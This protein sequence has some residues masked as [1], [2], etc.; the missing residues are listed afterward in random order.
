MTV[1]KAVSGLGI[2]SP[3]LPSLSPVPLTPPNYPCQSYP[4]FFE[5]Q[6]FISKNFFEHSCG[7][8]V[9]GEI[10]RM[11]RRYGILQV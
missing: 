8:G 5:L 10:G 3:G 2:I 7:E 4:C 9:G 1:V 11:L 6:I